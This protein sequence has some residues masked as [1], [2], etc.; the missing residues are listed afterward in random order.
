M[1]YT[2]KSLIGYRGEFFTVNATSNLSDSNQQLFWNNK[3][4][5]EISSA[6]REKLISIIAVSLH[7]SSCCEMF[8]SLAVL[9]LF[10]LYRQSADTSFILSCKSVWRCEYQKWRFSFT[11]FKLVSDHGNKGNENLFTFR[12][13]LR[14][15]LPNF[16]FTTNTS[17][18]IVNLNLEVDVTVQ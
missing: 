13:K 18:F 12:K 14:H 8:L 9:S 7:R 4:P 11:H 16:K 17:E 3:L 15:A 2:G 6:D 5:G 10:V 1:N